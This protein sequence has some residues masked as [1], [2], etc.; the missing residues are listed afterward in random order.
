MIDLQNFVLFYLPVMIMV[1][2]VL[3]ALVFNYLVPPGE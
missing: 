2:A 3:S 1:L